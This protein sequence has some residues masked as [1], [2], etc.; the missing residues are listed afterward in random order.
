MTQRPVC[1]ITGG[2]A[3]IGAAAARLAA[4]NFDLMLTYNSDQAGAE[5]TAA[6]CQ[7]LGARIEITKC[8]VAVSADVETLF[9]TLDSQ[10]GRIDALVN[11]AGIAGQTARLTDMDDARIAHLFA[12]NVVGAMATARETVRRMEAQGTGGTIVNISSAAARLGSPNQYVDYAATKGAIDTFT[13]GLAAEVAASNIRVVGI[14]PGIIDT[15]IHA[16]GGEPDRADRLAS[17]VPLGRK[18]TADEVAEA[19]VWLLS[20]KASYIT[21]TTLDVT[22]GR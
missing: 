7:A 19:I 3:G 10:F 6:A 8:D 11:N 17:A 1:L 21:G 22:G 2:S 5:A 15:A 18:G 12:V 20:P 13:T 4:P 14:R 9:A 16:K